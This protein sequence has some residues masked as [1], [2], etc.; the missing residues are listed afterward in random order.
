M[1]DDYRETKSGREVKYDS[2]PANDYSD[3][4][5]AGRRYTPVAPVKTKLWP[6]LLLLLLGLLVLGAVVWALMNASK[7]NDVNAKP[8]PAPTVVAPSPQPTSGVLP[9]TG[10]TN[11]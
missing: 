6:L 9:V 5:N 11:E 8:T 10:G 3:G 4:Y 2:D 1:K 7:N